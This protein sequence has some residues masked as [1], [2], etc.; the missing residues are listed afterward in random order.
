MKYKHPT[1]GTVVKLNRRRAGSKA[2]SGLVKIDATKEIMPFSGTLSL[3]PKEVNKVKIFG[4]I[5]KGRN[6][7]EQRLIRIKRW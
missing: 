4:Q 6:K 2:I 5:K 1:V 7:G 3:T